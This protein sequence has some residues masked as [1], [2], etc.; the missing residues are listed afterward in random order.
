M[1]ERPTLTMERTF[2]AP[3]ERVFDAF[4]S[5][6][7]MRRWWHAGSDWETPEATVDLRVGGEVRVVMRDPHKDVRYGGGGRY[8]EIEPPRK[9]AFSWVWDDDREQAEMLI[10]IEFS[11]RDGK[12]LMRFTHRDLWDQEAVASHEDGWSRAFENLRG[13]VEA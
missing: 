13:A 4:T 7:V 11:E 6:E 10:E 5:E 2:E 3:A 8:T 9:L 1:N 12:T